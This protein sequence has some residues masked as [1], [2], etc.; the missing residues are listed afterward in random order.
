MRKI[1]IAAG[2]TIVSQHTFAKQEDIG[3]DGY[4]NTYQDESKSFKDRM[5]DARKTPEVIVS[6]AK[7]GFTLGVLGDFGPLYDASPN[8][9]S[10]MGFGIGLE[11]GYV[12]QG[13]SWDRLDFSAKIGLGN[14]SW[15]DANNATSK[16]SPVSFV[17]RFGFGHAIGNDLFG[18]LKFG[19]GFAVG[20]IDSER[21][22]TTSSSPTSTGFV[23]SADYDLGF[24]SGGAQFVGGLGV[25][26]YTWT[27]SEITTDGI[28]SSDDYTLNL[29]HIN[30]HAGV[31]FK[32]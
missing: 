14:F 27:F 15:T 16:I 2:L 8:S 24:G 30:L 19:F 6:N 26:H 5:S 32:F 4:N 22:S 25:S 23:Y 17:P 13:D 20:A 7:G 18:T 10:G 29:N 11:P 31:R 21:G 1:L 9:R 12:V 28:K 3:D